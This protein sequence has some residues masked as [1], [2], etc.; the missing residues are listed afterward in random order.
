M[1]D[2][3]FA[4]QYRYGP[5]PEFLLASSCTSI[6]QCFSGPIIYAFT[7]TLLRASGL[8]CGKSSTCSTLTPH[9]N[10]FR[11]AFWVS[12][13][14]TCRYV[15]LLGPC[16][17][18]GETDPCCQPINWMQLMRACFM[19]HTFSQHPELLHSGNQP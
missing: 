14:K 4:H 2:E 6:V 18:T 8:C 3:R 11:F 7:Q 15:R 12:Y 13:P 19:L 10:H 9:S 1:S 17:K 16:S 5:P